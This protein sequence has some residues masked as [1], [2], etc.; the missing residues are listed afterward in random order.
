MKLTQQVIL[1]LMLPVIIGSIMLANVYVLHSFNQMDLSIKGTIVFIILV[2]IVFE[3][4]GFVT[5][6]FQKLFGQT[7]YFFNRFILPFLVSFIICSVI[8]FLLYIPIKLQQIKAGSRDSINLYHFITISSVLFFFVVVANAIHQIIFLIQKWQEESNRAAKLEKENMQSKLQVLKNQISPHF[9]FN[10]FNTLY[11]LIKDNSTI[12]GDFL[13]KLSAIYRRILTQRNEEVI[14]LEEEIKTVE[15]YFFLL[16][17][18][19]GKDIQF[20][21]SLQQNKTPYYIPPLT[22]Q[23]LLE[24]AIKHNSFDEDHPLQIHIIQNKDSVEVINNHYPH[25]GS[26]STGIGLQN[27]QNRYTILSDQKIEIEPKERTFCVRVP[28][29]SIQT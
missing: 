4:D 23:M 1:R 20:K 14:P 28:L 2:I 13:L 8:L 16:K 27:I 17:T 15:D 22:L 24:N 21:L 12:A 3:I 25:K 18:R 6:Y 19:F 9:L 10:N 5:R 29:L 7:A 11:G 26:F